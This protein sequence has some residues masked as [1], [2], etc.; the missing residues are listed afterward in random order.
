MLR[1]VI[2]V[3]LFLLCASAAASG[4]ACFK[5]SDSYM[6]ATYG[7]DFRD[8]ENLV[9]G[10]ERYGKQ[11]Y[12]A[13]RDKT[14]GTNHPVT[15]LMPTEGKGLCKV[16]TTYPIAA[17][18]PVKYDKNGR[19]IAFIAKDQGTTMH[20]IMYTWDQ[21]AAEFKPVRCRE[22]SWHESR[23]EA[24]NISCDGLHEQ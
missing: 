9:I 2:S 7:S 22:L 18:T 16:L 19:P 23:M 14:S 5:D 8:D 17:I 4:P 3:N 15:L 12:Y 21:S 6:V 1:S 11:V 20:E 10:K 24:K 13:A